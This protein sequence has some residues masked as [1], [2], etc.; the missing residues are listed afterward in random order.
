MEVQLF[1][2]M[3]KLDAKNERRVSV[4]GLPFAEK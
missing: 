3:M 4:V 2:K 1:N